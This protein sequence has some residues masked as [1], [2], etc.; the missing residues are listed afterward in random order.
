[1]ATLGKAGANRA[2]GVA[3]EVSST[4][5]PTG[6]SL[7]E[8]KPRPLPFRDISLLPSGPAQCPELP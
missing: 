4:A 7:T 2:P 3:R 1:V 8:T 6:W 5:A